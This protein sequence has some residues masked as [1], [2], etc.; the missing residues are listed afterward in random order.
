MANKKK[1]EITFYDE[2]EA[3]KVEDVYEWLLNYMQQCV[4]NGDVEAF[5]FKEVSND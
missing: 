5:N 4:R 1:F 3:E 2:V